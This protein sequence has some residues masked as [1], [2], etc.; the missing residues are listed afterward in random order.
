MTL[1]TLFH[2]KPNNLWCNIHFRH[3]ITPPVSDIAPTVSLSSQTLH[4]YHTHFWMTSHPPSVWHHMHYIEQHI[5]SL[6]HHNTLL[7]T[8]H[9]LYM[10]PHPVC[11]ATYTL[12]K[13]HHS[14]YLCPHTQSI[15]NITTTL[16]MTSHSPYVWHLLPYTN[17][18]ILILWHQ[19]SMFMSSQPLYLTSCPLCVDGSSHPL[20]WWYDNNCISE[21]TSA[22]VHN[23][24][25]IVY[26]MTPT[27]W[28]HNHCSWHQIPYISHH[29]QDLWHIVPYSCD[30]T[31]TMFVNTCNY[32]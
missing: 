3:D 6:C 25:S 15:D 20:Y 5:Q 19:T 30:I 32:I 23:I 18:H 21:I 17:Q 11:T 10:K 26:D 31:D 16:C 8:S 12:Y 22:I 7:M 1:H 4:W 2:I 28:H 14:Q 9:P 29:L 24:I 27:V 13:R